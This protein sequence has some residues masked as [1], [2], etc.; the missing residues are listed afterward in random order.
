MPF[1]SGFAHR[2]FEF[3]GRDR[4]LLSKRTLRSRFCTCTKNDHCDRWSSMCQLLCFFFFHLLENLEPRFKFQRALR[5]KKEEA[6][7]R[8]G[9]ANCQRRGQLLM[10]FHLLDGKSFL[11]LL[12]HCAHIYKSSNNSNNSNSSFSQPIDLSAHPIIMGKS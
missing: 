9:P 11:L 2:F 6:I 5:P 1:V 7:S 8:R 12:C 10:A 4:D 3:R